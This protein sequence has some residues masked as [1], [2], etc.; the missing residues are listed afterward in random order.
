MFSDPAVGFQRL[1][2]FG[3]FWLTITALMVLDALVWLTPKW[4]RKTEFGRWLFA[5]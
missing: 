4:I 1:K 3:G 5:E 2:R